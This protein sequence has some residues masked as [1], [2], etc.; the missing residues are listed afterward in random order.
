MSKPVTI[1]YVYILVNIAKNLHI[2][3]RKEKFC[4]RAKFM[5][6]IPSTEIKNSLHSF[7]CLL[8]NPLCEAVTPF[9]ARFVVIGYYGKSISESLSKKKSRS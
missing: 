9:I 2:V 3:I 4:Y 6:N 7:I 5:E 8:G 1:G